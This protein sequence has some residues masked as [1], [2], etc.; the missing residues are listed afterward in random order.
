MGL[1]THSETRNEQIRDADDDKFIN[2]TESTP[3]ECKDAI[4]N[5]TDFGYE[6]CEDYKNW[7][8]EYCSK[9]CGICNGQGVPTTTPVMTPAPRVESNCSDRIPDCIVY[10]SCSG[11]FESWARYRCQKYCKFCVLPEPEVCEDDDPNCDRLDSDLCWAPRLRI[12]RH[13]HCRRF[14]GLCPGQTPKK[15][16][17]ECKDYTDRCAHFGRDVCVKHSAWANH[18][19][20][21]YCGRCVTTTEP[22]TQIACVDRSSACQGYTDKKTQC[23]GEFYAWARWNCPVW[24]G[25]CTPAVTTP[26]ICFD[27]NPLCASMNSDLCTNI[28]FYNYVRENCAGFCK[29]CEQPF[30]P[31]C[32]TTTSQMTTMTTTLKIL[33]GKTEMQSGTAK[34]PSANT[35]VPTTGKTG[36][37]TGKSRV[38]PT[39]KIGSS[40][41]PTIGLTGVATGNSHVPTV[42]VTGVP[43]TGKTGETQVPTGKSEVP[44]G[45]TE[46]PT[47]QSNIPT[48]KTEISNGTTEVPSGTMDISKGT[49][50]IPNG[51][52]IGPTEAMGVST[53]TM[54]VMTGTNEVPTGTHEQSATKSY[55]MESYS[56]T[57]SNPTKKECV[58]GG[59]GYEEGQAWT[60]PEC[61]KSCKCIH[62]S[63][64]IIKCQPLKCPEEQKD[65]VLVSI[66]GQ[67]CPRL[68]C[69]FHHPVHKGK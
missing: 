63:S 33:T 67:C 7:S 18:W 38:P 28:K 69:A 24:C 44:N 54:E 22:T 11:P 15:P 3:K 51:T 52:V 43:M 68:E 55:S 57:P 40:Y 31:T 42:G 8:N 53:E 65:C 48:G 46:V 34:L 20:S 1:F 27:R 14:C 45:K 17:R 4:E 39:G 9:Y 10:D 60:T 41:V 59:M 12:F 61:D 19:C 64:N 23:C 66:P 47:G 13:K 36:V 49:M 37:P 56:S 26:R 35:G 50:K 21:G 2:V 25:F 32:G 30:E 5:C 16:P 58:Q 29:V 6:T 62:A